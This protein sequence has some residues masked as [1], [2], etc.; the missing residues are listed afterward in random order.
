MFVFDEWGFLV[1]T[2]KNE[3]EVITYE[4]LKGKS[5]GIQTG[6]VLDK[7]LP[8]IIEDVQI[9]YFESLSDMREALL[10]GKVD[11]ISADEPKLR[12]MSALNPQITYLKEVFEPMEY[13][14][15]FNKEKGQKLCNELNQYIKQI[16]D[17]GL[18]DQMVND[19]FDSNNLDR[20]MPD[21]E[22]DVVMLL[23]WQ[24]LN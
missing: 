20:Q 3:N 24:L 23:Q 1:H 13:G 8:N 18:F 17:S 14:F 7:I 6:S 2:Q 12:Y 5:V 4:Q 19:W 9:V 11:A 16:K 22:S 15:I 10:S 21:Y